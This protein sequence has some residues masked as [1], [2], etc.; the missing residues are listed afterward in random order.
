M[1]QR[2]KVRFAYQ[3][4]WQVV[5]GSAI[6]STF[7]K[8]EDAFRFVL[9]RGARVRLEWSRTVIGGKAPP[10]DFAAS[11]MQDRPHPEDAPRQ[12]SRDMVL[13]ML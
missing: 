12:R 6:L 2:L 10:Y 8:K 11:F 9:D 3:R 7:D 1:S 13:D 4:G 5:D